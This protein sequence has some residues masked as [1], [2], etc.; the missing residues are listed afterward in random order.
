MKPLRLLVVDDH[1][2]FRRSLMFPLQMEARIEVVGTATSG[3]QAVGLV[4]S[5][6]PDVVLMDLNMPYLSG[7][8]AMERI[9]P[10]EA[11]PAVLVLTGVDDGD[12]VLRAFAAGAAGYLRKDMITDEMLVSAIFTVASG[13]IFLDPKTFAVLRAVLPTSHPRLVEERL[14]LS[15]LS[16]DESALLR[17][18][19]LGYD[20]DQIGL[21]LQIAA[22]TASNR[23]S[24]I[25]LHLRVGNRV[26]ASN[27]ALRNGLVDINDT[28]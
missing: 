23:L 24:Q 10:D 4:R 21:K 6:R 8:A 27:L 1:D 3:D 5:A 12:S 16:P 2:F 7:L 15:R 18:V 17:Y 9:T 20:N 26:Q 11:A 13:G 25:Y 28:L 19:A 14:R 22:K